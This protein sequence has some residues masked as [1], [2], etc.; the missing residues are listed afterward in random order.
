MRKAAAVT[1]AELETWPPVVNVADAAR[2]LDVSRATA[3]AALA[4]GNLPVR[5]IRVGRRIKVVTSSIIDA[6]SVNAAA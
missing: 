3:Y 1:I 4:E 5:T 2:A 6:L